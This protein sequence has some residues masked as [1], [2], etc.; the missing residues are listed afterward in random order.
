MA[1][2]VGKHS[3]S[4]EYCDTKILTGFYCL[5]F[6]WTARRGKKSVRGV[7]RGLRIMI[8]DDNSNCSRINVIGIDAAIG[9]RVEKGPA[10][11]N[12]EIH[13]F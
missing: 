2:A 13:K 12:S 1:L 6:R 9:A 5:S 11:A 3:N 4:I 8:G 7:A 10:V